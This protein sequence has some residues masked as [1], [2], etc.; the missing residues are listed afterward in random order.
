MAG[1]S[2]LYLGNSKHS[3]AFGKKLKTY[4]CCKEL[5]RRRKLTLPKQAPHPVD[6]ILFETPNRLDDVCTTLDDILEASNCIPIV[7]ITVR[8][9]EHLGIAAVQAGAQAYICSDSSSHLEVNSTI[10]DTFNRQ[11][12]FA[13][14][15]KTD[16]PALAILTSVNEGGMLVDC[17]GRIL[18]MSPAGRSM[19]GLAARQP[20]TNRWASTFC[21]VSPDGATEI[22]YN[23]LPITKA[24]RGEQFS[25]Q[26]GAYLVPHQ[27][28]I[29]LSTS[30]R[31]LFSHASHLIGG[32]I[33]F[34]DVTDSVQHA[35]HL[36]K[37][38]Q[39]DPLTKLPN[40]QM[41]T[42]QLQKAMGRAQ[43][44]DRLLAVLFLNL[45]RFKS[46]NDTL[47][48]DTGDK[49][50]QQV[51]S[52]LAKNLR[53]GDFCSR[54]DSDQFIVCL[55][56]LDEPSNAAS[57]A[58]KLVLVL[59]DKYEV[60]GSEVYITPSIGIVVYPDKHASTA[61]WLI[62]AA[63]SAMQRAKSR[64]G[65]RFEYYSAALNENLRQLE[66]LEFGLRHAL[67]RDEFLLHYQPRIDV[68]T[69]K[70]L[71][72]EA[73]LRWQHPSHGLLMPA[74][75]LPILE[76]TGLI[77][78]AGEWVINTALTN[79]ASWQNKFNMPDLSM[80][81][82]ISQQQLKQGRLV[83]TVYKAIT[84]NAIDPGC[85]EVEMPEGHIV[86]QRSI[87][88]KTLHNLRKLGVRL[89]LDH[90]GVRDVSVNSLEAGGIDSFVLDQS[91]IQD[92][93][94]NTS[95]QR[96]VKTAIAIAR[97][98]DI[99]VTAEGVE[100]IPQLDFLKNCNCDIAQ[101]FLISQPMHTE[102]VANILRGAAAG[103]PLPGTVLQ[104]S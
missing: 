32:I 103:K 24:C 17:N 37:Q 5:I 46:I 39:F 102:K 10:E 8:A 42:N 71:G 61:D 88:L 56:D 18:S 25:E 55:E 78:S 35:A 16:R 7:A 34:R 81:I 91:L 73:L 49:L 1:H 94:T 30:G 22:E 85:V 2:I 74:K 82:N 19:L 12:L 40:C 99:E 66:K 95:N 90:F 14:L 80:T 89:S 67:I 43:R 86:R 4:S 101:G 44:H 28:D 57:A 93:T 36:E 68:K 98:L 33:T 100:T 51:G 62:K 58:Q 53:V 54:Q 96:A 69:G 87:E 50:L 59:A 20:L 63:E 84:N 23:D 29:I 38:V 65:S 92:V 79:L 72:L 41:F 76:S 48:H 9:T 11:R 6:L 13:E 83:D 97:G 3:A 52:R 47:G 64:G 15:R 77:H 31:G 70:L 75:F 45:D 104:S 27:G 60:D 26:L 21:C